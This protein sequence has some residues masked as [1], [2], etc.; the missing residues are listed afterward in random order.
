M[1]YTYTDYNILYRYII[2]L[3]KTIIWCIRAPTLPRSSMGYVYT[4]NTLIN[5]STIVFPIIYR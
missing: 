4:M 3:Y 1:T 2:L 5:H